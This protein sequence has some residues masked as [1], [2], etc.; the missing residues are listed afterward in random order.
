MQNFVW[1]RTGEEG[2]GQGEGFGWLVTLLLGICD[3][4]GGGGGILHAN[5]M[6]FLHSQL[7]HH[8]SSER[9]S[10]SIMKSCIE[11]EIEL[12]IG[13]AQLPIFLLYCVLYLF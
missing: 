4:G 3:G 13:R 2:R 1:E 12:G 8:Q 10:K 5:R 11:I 6:L 7:T 9:R